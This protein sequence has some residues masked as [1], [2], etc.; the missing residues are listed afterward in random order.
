MDQIQGPE[1]LQAHLTMPWLLLGGQ[2]AVWLGKREGAGECFVEEPSS[3][4]NHS[5]GL[6]SSHCHSNGS[7]RKWLV[8][9]TTSEMLNIDLDVGGEGVQS[10]VDMPFFRAPIAAWFGV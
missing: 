10:P 4:A 3:S 6:I 5:T 2:L 8:R 9:L 1:A 7:A